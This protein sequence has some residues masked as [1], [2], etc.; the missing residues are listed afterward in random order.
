MR[1]DHELV[2]QAFSVRESGEIKIGS[3]ENTAVLFAG[4][5]EKNG[6]SVYASHAAAKRTSTKFYVRAETEITQHNRVVFC[7]VPYT[8]TGISEKGRDL[9]ELSAVQVRDDTCSVYRRDAQV[10]AYKRPICGVPPKVME[11]PAVL[12]EKYLGFTQN[13]PMAQTQTTFVLVTPK[14]VS[15]KIAGLVE[16]N[17]ARY[18]VRICHTLDEYKSSMRLHGWK[19]LKNF[20]GRSK[21]CI[22]LHN[23]PL[24]KVP[25]IE[26]FSRALEKDLGKAGMRCRR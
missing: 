1:M 19:N 24:W 14:E 21:S 13:A 16:V 4:K 22:F 10:D 26:V 8:L 3:W 6:L 15:L 5:E 12:V 20:Y 18:A 17:D 25:V 11:F 9:L 2:I 7:G 23:P